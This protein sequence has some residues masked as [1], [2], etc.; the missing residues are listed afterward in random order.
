MRDRWTANQVVP[1]TDQ[2]VSNW[3]RLRA[4]AFDVGRQD[5]FEHI[6][7]G[8][9]DLSA[10]MTRNGIEHVFEEFEGNHVNA[11]G[12]RLES[13]VQPFFSQHLRFAAATAKQE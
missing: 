12:N 8:T 13:R 10:A 4:I 1:F 6:R 5:S 3:R 9:R 7:A 11:V 2:Y